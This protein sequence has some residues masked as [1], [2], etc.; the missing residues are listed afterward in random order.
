MARVFSPGL[1]RHLCFVF[2]VLAFGFDAKGKNF[3]MGGIQPLQFFDKILTGSNSSKV[4]GFYVFGYGIFEIL[5]FLWEAVS[6]ESN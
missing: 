4:F 1:V 5:R 3:H 6:E 2:S